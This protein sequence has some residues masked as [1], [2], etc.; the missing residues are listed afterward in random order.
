MRHTWK[1][2]FLLCLFLSLG[3]SALATEPDNSL[4]IGTFNTYMLPDQG[5][6]IPPTYA[7]LTP[8]CPFGELT[9]EP[10]LWCEIGNHPVYDSAQINAGAKA[11]AQRIIKSG[12]DVI[13]L[14]EVFD[15]SAQ[16]ILRSALWDD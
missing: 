13:A 7:G 12:Y 4:R 5:I 10:P 9:P 8:V 15:G 16:G 1:A 2:P 3:I 6:L 11:L 14:N